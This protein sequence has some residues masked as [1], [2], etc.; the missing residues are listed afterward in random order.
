M[1]T[2]SKHSSHW[3]QFSSF[4]VSVVVH[5]LILGAMWFIRNEIVQEQ[6]QLA[7]ESVLNDDER[8]QEEITQQLQEST[9]IA[10]NMNT[11]SGGVVSTNVGSSTN[12]S[13]AKVKMETSDLVKTEV[14]VNAAQVNM[15]GDSDLGDDLGEGEV[16]GNIGAMVTGYGPALSQMTQELIRL[17]R[18]QKILVVWLF[19]Q[20]DSMKDDQKEIA[21]NFHK[22]YEELGLA[23]KQDEKLKTRIKDQI[24]QT[25][26]VAYGEA[27]KPMYKEPT[28]DIKVI[29]E[30]ITKIPIDESG[31][32]NMCAA[33]QA[34][35]E[36]YGRRVQRDKRKLL[37][38][39]V[40][41]E[42]GDDGELVEPTIEKVKQLKAPVYILGR[43]S[44]FG[45]PYARIRWQDPKYHLWHWLRINRGPETAYPECLQWDG[46]HSRWDVHNSGFGPYEQVRLVKE[47]GGVFYVLPGEEE[48]LSGEGARERREYAALDMKPYT[49]LL[50]PRREYA[51]TVKHSKFRTAIWE[52]IVR[53][54]PTKHQFLPDFPYNKELNIREH[55][56]PLSPAEF[57]Q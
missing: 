14:K 22:V 38:V 21:A 32:E 25:M 16:T 20:S 10:T 4:G 8:V 12:P 49:P 46:L 15:P 43:E 28:A 41:D 1:S 37:I 18:E 30:A 11:I 29:E 47:S 27:V 26:I 52:V 5:A 19:D 57:P 45:Y 40:S 3:K 53:L 7:V 44:V 31:K 34:V 9:E 13:M 54:N 42:S 23:Q 17:M 24:L 36:E 50:L 35:A 56:Y 48:D 2:E 51:E 6:E 55:W 39:V 33:I